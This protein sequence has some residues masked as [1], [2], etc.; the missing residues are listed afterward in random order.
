MKAVLCD[1]DGTLVDS[2]A[3]HA[4]AWQRAFAHFGISVTFDDLLH[5][6]GKGGDHLLPVFLSKKDVN[7]FGKDL[8]QYRKN[9][10]Q[11]EYFDQVKPFP[12]SRQL[13]LKMKHAGLRVSIASSASKEDL[14]RLK[15]IAQISDLVEEETSSDD[16]KKSKPEGDIFQSTLNQLGVAAKEALALGDTPWDVE[17]AR[18]AGLA[19]VAVTSGGWSQQDLRNAGALEVYRDVAQIAE[20]FEQSA[21]AR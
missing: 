3:L 17:A 14:Q 10:F 12:G 2:N 11:A 16:A 8:E 13:L 18:K 9:L 7:R 20:Q 19:T 21:F 5:Q 6:I 1:V 4:E 15:Q